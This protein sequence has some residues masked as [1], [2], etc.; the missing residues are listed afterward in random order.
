MY[1]IL[2]LMS[3][4]PLISVVM[5]A[6]NT[7][8]YVTEAVRSVLDQTYSPI[9]LICIDD[10][11]TDGTLEIL[12]GFGDKI[13][14]ISDG[15]NVGIGEARNKG[16]RIA[17]GDFIAFADS[18][19]IWDPKKLELQMQQFAADPNLDISFCIIQNFLSPDVSDEIRATRDVPPDPMPGQISGT[20]LA[21]KSSFDR[22]G[23]LDP[24]YRVGEFID[25]MARANNLGLK[26][27][28]INEVLYLRRIHATNT[29]A[30]KPAHADYLK[31]MKAAIERKR[32]AQS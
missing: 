23:L 2:H 9:E 12:K 3:R 28:M 5:P 13:R 18:D 25:W 1:T 10:G 11:S 30:N 21:K 19:D 29:T 15:T 31:I 8:K 27:S 16:I 24:S 32:A 14:V 4:D 26:N 17:T 7:E 22:V 6:Y 20:F